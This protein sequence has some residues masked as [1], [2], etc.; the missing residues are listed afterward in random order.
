MNDK[1]YFYDQRAILIIPFHEFA[2]LLGRAEPIGDQDEVYLDSEAIIVKS[3][4]DILTSYSTSALEEK[5]YAQITDIRKVCWNGWCCEVTVLSDALPNVPRY[6]VPARL[7]LGV[8]QSFIAKALEDPPNKRLI[9][10]LETEFSE[11]FVARMKNRMATSYYKYGPIKKNYAD[12]STDAIKEMR[13][14]I[15]KYKETG[16]TE[17]LADAAN[18]A[19]I[20]FMYPQH[21]E[22]HFRAT[23]SGESPGLVSRSQT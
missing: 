7:S 12:G 11:T 5:L 3:T 17:W 6:G 21:D 8:Y 16:N 14:R 4:K 20:E 13:E 10:I 9:A 23:D 22:A 2:H 18:F 19:M 15:K 1:C